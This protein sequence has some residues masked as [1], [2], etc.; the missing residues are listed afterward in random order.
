LDT[1][2]LLLFPFGLTIERWLVDDGRV[3]I[4]ARSEESGAPCPSCDRHSM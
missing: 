1:I 3:T 4:I 2:P